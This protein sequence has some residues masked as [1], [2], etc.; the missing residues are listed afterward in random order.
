MLILL[1][2]MKADG[3]KRPGR[4]TRKPG[5]GQRVRFLADTGEVMVMEEP[6]KCN[7]RAAFTNDLNR[8]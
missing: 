2:N 3:C 6:G 1:V 7:E 5:C 4:A 8:L